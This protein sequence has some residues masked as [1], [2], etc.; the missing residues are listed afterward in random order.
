MTKFINLINST[1]PKN[2]KTV[3]TKLVGRVDV[4]EANSSP[5]EF[6][7]VAFIGSDVSYGDVFKAWQNGKEDNFYLY[8]GI[9]GDE[10][11]S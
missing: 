9:K 10:F 5:E 4:I 7:Y 11:N 3:F 2:K 1:K 8:F 6:D